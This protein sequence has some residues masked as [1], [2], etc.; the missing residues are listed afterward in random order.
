VKGGERGAGAKSKT[1]SGKGGGG[2][3]GGSKGGGGAT[4]GETPG[5][6]A[7]RRSMP[8][9]FGRMSSTAPIVLRS[10]GPQPRRPKLRGLRAP[11]DQL[12]VD[13]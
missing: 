4:R 6:R 2:R 11:V 12:R 7:C 8:S 10:P 1:T 3:S 9:R 13:H 5:E